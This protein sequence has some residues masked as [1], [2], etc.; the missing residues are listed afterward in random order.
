MGLYAFIS[1]AVI[2][3]FALKAWKTWIKYKERSLEQLGAIEQRLIKIE[4]SSK[5]KELEARIIHLE[6]IITSDEHE[7]KRKFRELDQ[8][9][10]VNIR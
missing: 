8:E 2:S 9:Q 7:L 5:Q 3:S 4:S 1:I 6:D 10:G